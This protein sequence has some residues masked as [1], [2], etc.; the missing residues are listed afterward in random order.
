VNQGKARSRSGRRRQSHEGRLDC[1]CRALR[2]GDHE[3]G[4]DAQSSTPAAPVIINTRDV[5]PAV[6]SVVFNARLLS[7]LPGTLLTDT[8]RFVTSLGTCRATY[9]T[10]SITPKASSLWRRAVMA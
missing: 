5:Q 1:D 10:I 3:D 8:V 7:S 4:V 2:T 9:S 6:F